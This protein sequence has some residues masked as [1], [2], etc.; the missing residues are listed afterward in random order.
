VEREFVVR[1]NRRGDELRM[2]IVKPGNQWRTRLEFGDLTAEGKVDERHSGDALRLDSYFGALAEDWRGWEGERGW[3]ALG[4]RLAARHDG[5]GHV[6]LD[7]TLD[8]QPGWT[9]RWSVRATLV[10][11]GR[12]ARGP[13]WRRAETRRAIAPLLT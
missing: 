8:D 13:R 7:V 4:L 2:W 10:V 11:D 9:E 1:S 6:A 12:R 3:E 5:L